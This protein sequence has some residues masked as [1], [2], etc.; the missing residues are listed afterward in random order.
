MQLAQADLSAK[1]E[2]CRYLIHWAFGAFE[3][4]AREEERRVASQRAYEARKAAAAARKAADAASGQPAFVK[5]LRSVMANTFA[6]KRGVNAETRTRHR[7]DVMKL[8]GVLEATAQ[9]QGVELE[10]IK[11]RVLANVQR[12]LESDDERAAAAA[13]GSVAPNSVA[14]RELDR[15]PNVCSISWRDTQHKTA[16]IPLLRTP[17][18]WLT[19]LRETRRSRLSQDLTSSHDSLSTCLL[20][21]F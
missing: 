10:H 1:L 14:E 20:I 19:H 5:G 2:R 3:E 7:I 21:S 6:G 15:A 13:V 18:P 12:I 11:R 8:V 17:T 4:Q 16:P 9:F